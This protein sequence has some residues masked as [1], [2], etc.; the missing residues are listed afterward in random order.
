VA[1][2]TITLIHVLKH[3]AIYSVA[4]THMLK[5]VAIAG[6]LGGVAA[7][8]GEFAAFVVIAAGC[9]IRPHHTSGRQSRNCSENERK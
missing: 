2:Y 3:A 1:I 6:H 9:E 4:L 7:I 8:G 5:D